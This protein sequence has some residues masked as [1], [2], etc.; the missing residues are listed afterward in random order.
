VEVDIPFRVI[1]SNVKSIKISKSKEVSKEPL[2]VKKLEYT[3]FGAIKSKRIYSDD[4]TVNWTVSYQYKSNNKL[5][6]KQ[7]E[8]PDGETLW[9]T[10]YDYDA[11]NRLIRK[12]TFDSEGDSDYTIL[13]E[14]QADRTEVLAYNAEGSLQWRKKIVTPKNRNTRETYFY[15]PEGT[16][17]KVIVENFKSNDRIYEEIHIDEIGTVFRRIE[18]EYDIFGRVTGRIVYDDQGNVHR[19][20][21]IEYL[22]HG[23]I[24]L[25]RQVIP[26]DNRVEEHNYSYKFDDR[27][28]WIYRKEI[29]TI[30]DDSLKE[31]K[32]STTI[33]TRDIDYFSDVIGPQ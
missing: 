27:G 2:P 1:P 31:P 18:T 30:S 3:S 7:A 8:S 32:V 26:P 13:Y 21:W 29:T 12:T 16:R 15:Y 17:I 10:S 19:R 14:Y 9:S 22:P 24:G 5:K 6:K 25:V 23:H 33:K 20:V 11:K 28:S 4:G